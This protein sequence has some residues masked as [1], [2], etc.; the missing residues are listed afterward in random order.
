MQL[1]L[2]T[3]SDTLNEST[4][5][6]TNVVNA[7]DS[8]HSLDNDDARLGISL[9]LAEIHSRLKLATMMINAARA[10]TMVNSWD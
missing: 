1:A 8:P 7:I 5:L 6:L 10:T 4:A 3:L 2:N 9:V